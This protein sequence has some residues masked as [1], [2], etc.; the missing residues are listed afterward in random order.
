MKIFKIEALETVRKAKVFIHCTNTYIRQYDC[1]RDIPSIF[2][3]F[4]K[5][6]KTSRVVNNFQNA[7]KYMD[8]K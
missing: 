2:E 8:N 3:Q 6:L 1:K 5:A 4:L 7:K